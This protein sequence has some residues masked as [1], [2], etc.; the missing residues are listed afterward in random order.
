MPKLILTA[1]ILFASITSVQAGGAPK[2][3]LGLVDVK[4]AASS[5]DRATVRNCRCASPRFRR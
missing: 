3:M 1:A 4:P 5:R 2:N